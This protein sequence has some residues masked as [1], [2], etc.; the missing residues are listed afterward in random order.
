M[1]RPHRDRLDPSGE[2]P[3]QIQDIVRAFE[4][5]VVR[6]LFRLMGVKPDVFD[7]VDEVA[8]QMN[9]LYGSLEKAATHL[10]ALGWI[11]FRNMPTEVYTEAADLAA[12]GNASEAEQVLVVGW[13]EGEHLLWQLQRIKSLGVGDPNSRAIFM[14]RWE[15]LERA[16]KHHR[17]RAYEASVLIILTQMDGLVI[18]V[19]GEHRQDFFSGG[20][21]LVDE[22]T[23]AG[24][25]EGLKAIARIMNR[26][27]K[28]TG[29][30]GQLSR[31][32][33]MHGRELGYDTVENSTKAFA[34]LF[35]LIE[36]AQPIVQVKAKQWL[37]DR[38][39]KYAGSKDVDEEGR[40]MDRRGFDQAKE[41]LM[42]LATF[43]FGHF[44]RHGASARVIHEILPTIMAPLL[45]VQPSD[46]VLHTDME[47]REYWMYT[48]TPADYVFGVA[49]R[50]GEQAVWLYASEHEPVGGIAN[51]D[52][53]HGARDPAHVE[54]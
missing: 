32:G 33:I 4:N 26:D 6:G 50:D 18:D 31:H 30:T 41:S 11:P 45:D 53:R 7:K 10:P 14:R 21:H 44:R 47:G 13:N 23:L 1:V 20:D 16:R 17:N 38:E 25:P 42:R 35:A 29:E 52:W 19:T 8:A 2:S 34:A 51:D 5:P 40:R 15:L 37:Q 24:H 49:G 3:E 46:I 27:V 36:W 39:A 28:H 12:A 54:W 9:Q 43:Q 48:R 22:T